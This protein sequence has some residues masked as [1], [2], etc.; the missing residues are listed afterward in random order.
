MSAR[1]ATRRQTEF[2]NRDSRGRRVLIVDD[3]AALSRVFDRAL[4]ADGHDVVCV[5]DGAE[6]VRL[7]QAQDFDV[8][9][10]DISMPRL[11]G[12]ELL[13]AV[14]KN[15]SDIPVVLVTGEP[16]VDTAIRAVEYE[17]FR[18][19]KKPVNL[20]LLKDVVRRAI[21]MRAFARIKREALE[22][23]GERSREAAERAAL[24]VSLTSAI[25]TVWM[26]FQP[27]VQ[28]ST[29]RPHGYEALLRTRNDR[30]STPPLL[31]EAAEQLE[32]VHE[33]GRRVRSRVAEAVPHA[34]ADALIFVNV[35]PWEL[36]DDELYHDGAS[37]S[38]CAEQI[39][40][41]VTE[42]AQLEQLGDL[43][44]RLAKLRS[45]GYRIAVDDLGDGYSGLTSFVRLQPEYV[46]VDI[47]LIRAVHLSPTKQR[48]LRSMF[49]LCRDLDIRAVA[50]GV[51]TADELHTLLDLGADLLQGYLFGRPSPRFDSVT[52]QTLDM[53]PRLW[54]DR[55]SERGA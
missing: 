38:R 53:W 23:S 47:S 41:E 2:S 1:V 20:D 17:A 6:A 42:R 7:L 13:E 15:S 29:G 8:I 27:I 34:P 54:R 55:W 36:S 28:C 35:H 18:Y 51:E 12:I 25:D 31:L 11:G 19:L 50:E 32:R 4:K 30:L 49:E 48:L 5:S 33:I 45:L 3:D 9:V 10:S 22:L 43:D 26:N 40:L 39:V 37:L 46:K 52:T 16:D 14:R 21:K 24:D 44:G